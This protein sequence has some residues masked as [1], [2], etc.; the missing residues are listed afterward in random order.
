[1]HIRAAPL[2]TQPSHMCEQDDPLQTAYIYA[3]KSELCVFSFQDV[4]E[5]FQ[6]RQRLCKSCLLSKRVYY[7]RKE[8]AYL[9]SKLFSFTEDPLSKRDLISRK[10]NRKSQMLSSILTMAETLS[11]VPIFFSNQKSNQTCS[12]LLN[13]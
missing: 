10:A 2:K 11:T 5:H 12:V 7:K 4:W 8:V 9:A 1:M 13:T 3:V 6:G